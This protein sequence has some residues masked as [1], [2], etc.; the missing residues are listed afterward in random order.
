[1]NKY[2]ADRRLTV[3]S[4]TWHPLE[5]GAERQLRQISK[6]LIEHGWR[7]TVVAGG[8]SDETQ[9][10]R[11]ASG[12]RVL[13][14]RNPEDGQ[15]LPTGRRLVTGCL[16]VARGTDPHVVLGSLVSGASLAA[17][18]YGRA[19]RVPRVLRIGGDDFSRLTSAIGRAQGRFLVHSS[20]AIVVNAPHL[21]A[22]IQPFAQRNQPPL[23][24]I[25]NGVDI[26][27]RSDSSP[28]P[29]G[30]VRVIYYTNAGPAKNDDD[31]LRIVARLPDIQFRAIGRTDHLDAYPNL[32]VRGWRASPESELQWADVVLNTS[33]TEGS[34][35][36]C[37]QGIALGRHVVGFHNGGIADLAEL[38]PNYVTVVR[39]RDVSAAVEALMRSENFELSQK[40]ADV[41]S[42]EQAALEWNALLTRLLAR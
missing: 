14:V 25:R 40:H 3:F 26:S 1:M 12:V 13:R 31:F 36:F 7:I 35:N 22:Q 37:L 34:P 38:Y 2:P 30:P 33:F 29:D 19:A 17:M 28:R 8:T 41:P 10:E 9:E 42:I 24:V 5:G 4:A 39:S 11:Q 18:A 20:D 6:A 23:T 15:S 27:R 32:E 16:R 21:R